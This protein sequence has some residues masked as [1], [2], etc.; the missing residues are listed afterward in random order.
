MTSQVASGG[1]P[2]QDDCVPAAPRAVF[3]TV[4][5]GGVY[6]PPAASLLGVGAASG[7]TALVGGATPGSP[8]VWGAI[9]APPSS[10]AGS[11]LATVDFGGAASPEDGLAVVTVVGCPWAAA[12]GTMIYVVTLES[13]ADHGSAAEEAALEGLVTTVGN[14][15]VGVGFDLFCSA[16][17]GSWGQW[18]FRVTGVTL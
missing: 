15:V 1:T 5:A 10:I 14:V 9:P 18:T 16:P 13:S 11:A 2:V 17:Q 8:P 6:T 3:G 7:V 12:L 4:D